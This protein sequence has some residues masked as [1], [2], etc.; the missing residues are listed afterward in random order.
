MLKILPFSS[1]DGDSHCPSPLGNPLSHSLPQATAWG[2]VHVERILQVVVTAVSPT[3]DPSFKKS[4]S[5]TWMLCPLEYLH[6]TNPIINA[7]I[8]VGTEVGLII[9]FFNI[10]FVA[11]GLSCSM[12]GL[13]P[14]LGI[15][16]G[17]LRWERRVSA[18]GPAGKS[19]VIWF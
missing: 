15:K 5:K 9:F 13:I 8:H 17:P 4:C 10:Y 12:W 3:Q 14:W 7:N 11:P 19:L 1:I 2:F 16:L 18:I 6:A